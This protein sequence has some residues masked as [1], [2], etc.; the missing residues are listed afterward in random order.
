[1][2]ILTILV[3]LVVIGFA[4]WLATSYIPM[5]EILQASRDRDR[6]DP[7]TA[8]VDPRGGVNWIVGDSVTSRSRS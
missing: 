3:V 5:P 1:M 8:L 6:R 7:R 4:L 2:S